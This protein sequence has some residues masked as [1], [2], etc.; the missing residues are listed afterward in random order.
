MGAGGAA[1]LIGTPL[2]LVG[3]LVVGL[4]FFGSTGEAGACV[5]QDGPAAD[6]LALPL[7]PGFQMTDDYGPR[8]EPVR[9]SGS[10]HPAV[11]LQN[12]PDPCGKPVYAITGGEVIE[13]AGFRL[14]IRS[15]DGYVVSYLHMELG[16]ILVSLHDTVAPGQRI[17]A[18]GNAGP[19]TGCHLDL[20]IKVTAGAEG[21]IAALPRSQTVGG[22]DDYVSPE[23][24][25]AA[26]GSALCP[27]ETCRRAY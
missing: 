25:Y 19:S 5:P 26:L 21:P 13:K 14:S 15:A 6:C 4:L 23:D 22:P 8:D 2:V 27:P 7:D 1:A 10:W 20:R 9:G 12:W 16:D 24:F 11:D 3:G 18:V 17:G